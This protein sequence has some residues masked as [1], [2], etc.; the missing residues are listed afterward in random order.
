MGLTKSF[1]CLS[2]RCGLFFGLGFVLQGSLLKE[3]PDRFLVNEVLKLEPI[4]GHHF[5]LKAPNQCGKF[6]FIEKTVSK[7][8]CQLSEPGK[9]SIVVNICDDNESFCKP[10]RFTVQVSAPKGWK[11][12]APIVSRPQ[13]NLSAP[14]NV[15]QPTPAGFLSNAPEQALQ[16]A[17]KNNRLMLIDFYG[18]W[19]P[20][21]N[22]LDEY[23]FDEASFQRATAEMVKLSMDVDA[24]SSW[25]WVDHFHVSFYP[26][27][28]IANTDLQE[29]GRLVGLYIYPYALVFQK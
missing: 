16:E 9:Q 25:D 23:V 3:A 1:Q 28:I 6:S 17:R 14:K 21:C 2:Q 4:S 18:I 5:N 11:K 19:C 12:N 22:L 29:V 7:L 20:P 10:E 27:L 13:G 8:T 24:T 26:T 15:Q